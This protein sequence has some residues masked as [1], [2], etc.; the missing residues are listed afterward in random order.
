MDAGRLAALDGLELIREAATRQIPPSL[1]P[2][3]HALACSLFAAGTGMLNWI[4]LGL[5]LGSIIFAAFTGRLGE[6]QDAIY[7]SAEN[8]VTLIIGLVGIM[9]FMLGLMRVA[10]EGGLLRF[11]GR[12]VSHHH[13]AGQNHF[14]PLF[15]TLKMTV[16]IVARR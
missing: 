11:I 3:S 12:N 14:L 15:S 16:G 9:V 10:Q 5:I 4:W 8:A 6:V 13:H 2:S 7:D 1:W